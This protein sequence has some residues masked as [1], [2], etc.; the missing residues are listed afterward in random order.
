MLEILQARL[1]RFA[2]L[3]GST[4]IDAR[5]TGLESIAVA[6]VEG[7]RDEATRAGLRFFGSTTLSTGQSPVQAIPTTTAQFLIYTPNWNTVTAYFDRLGVM[8]LSGTGGAGGVL[9]GCMV[10]FG[11]IPTTIPTMLASATIRNANPMSSR[12]SNLVIASPATL[13][14]TAYANSWY[15]LANMYRADTVLG[16]TCID[17][18][19]AAGASG[20]EAGG[21][22]LGGSLQGSIVVAPGTA[23]AL[24]VI[25]P[26]G[27]TPKYSIHFAHREYT[28]DTE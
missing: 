27:T 10:P 8:L 4:P 25:A 11:N 12:T 24:A 6:Q 15:P 28:S 13:Q 5:A 22:T 16:Q 14:A 26:T 3:E 18:S 21:A 1:R 2:Q 9:L 23:L 17:T 20:G 7:S 19:I